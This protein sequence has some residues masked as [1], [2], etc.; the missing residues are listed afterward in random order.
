MWIAAA[1]GRCDTPTFRCRHFDTC[2][3]NPRQVEGRTRAINIYAHCVSFLLLPN[4]R[5]DDVARS[6]SKVP[7]R[8]LF[9]MK[10]RATYAGPAR[11][12]LADLFVFGSC[13]PVIL[14]FRCRLTPRY[15][16]VDFCS[17]QTGSANCGGRRRT[18]SVFFRPPACLPSST[19]ALPI[20]SSLSIHLSLFLVA[21]ALFSRVFAGFSSRCP[22]GRP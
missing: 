21:S 9:I 7:T 13:H 1:F 19:A 12:R 6:R 4:Q 2:R 16:V 22:L 3:E 17:L 8:E 20:S 11:N 15:A 18:S 5:R 10:R 14:S